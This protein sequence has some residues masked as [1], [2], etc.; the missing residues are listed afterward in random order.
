M[1]WMCQI[2]IDNEISWQFVKEILINLNTKTIVAIL[3]QKSRR[4]VFKQ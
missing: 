4:M 1:L 3:S 2:I